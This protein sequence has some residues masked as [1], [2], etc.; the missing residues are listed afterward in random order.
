MSE[1]RTQDKKCIFLIHST[2]WIKCSVN[3]SPSEIKGDSHNYFNAILQ[4][5]S[6]TLVC[7]EHFPL[8]LWCQHPNFLWRNIPPPSHVILLVTPVRISHPAGYVPQGRPQW[9]ASC[10]M[11]LSKIPL[12]QKKLVD[13]FHLIWFVIM[14]SPFSHGLFQRWS[15][16]PP[17]KYFFMTLKMQKFL[18]LDI[19]TL[20]WNSSIFLTSCY[21]H[22]N[23]SIFYL[24][25]VLYVSICHILLTTILYQWIQ[26]LIHTIV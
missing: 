3:F 6:I 17:L 16:Q 13:H 10:Y 5:L 25:S 24:H 8:L 18:M 9:P 22:C 19:K 21:A 26:S 15:G 14:D 23:L 4:W 2:N 11:S 20:Y 7:P 12:C 1:L